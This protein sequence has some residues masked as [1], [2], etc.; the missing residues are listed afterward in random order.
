MLTLNAYVLPSGEFA[1]EYNERLAAA[2][3]A[4]MADADAP[5]AHDL[6]PTILSSL[7][8]FFIT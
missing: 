7:V 4:E 6:L 5:A 8:P 3:A 1:E 2:E